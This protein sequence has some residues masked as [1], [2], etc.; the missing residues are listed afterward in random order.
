M[1][2]GP[3]DPFN[4]ELHG[5][6]LY[7]WVEEYLYKRGWRRQGDTLWFSNPDFDEFGENVSIGYAFEIQL[8]HDGIDLE[9][10]SGQWEHL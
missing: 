4:E 1:S 5:L 3:V 7:S 8:R 9:I 6:R 2:P 10:Q